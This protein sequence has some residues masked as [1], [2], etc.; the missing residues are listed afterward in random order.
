MIAS[1]KSG[2][3]DPVAGIEKRSQKR[4][5]DLFITKKGANEI[6]QL[7]AFNNTEDRSLSQSLDSASVICPSIMSLPLQR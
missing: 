3:E 5:E 2:S 6:K 7:R 4:A 1:T